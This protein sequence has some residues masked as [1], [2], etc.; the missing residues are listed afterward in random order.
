MPC[1]TR[2]EWLQGC[3]D[4]I[5]DDKQLNPANQLDTIIE[6]V[7]AQLLASDLRDS[8][9]HGSGIPA[10]IANNDTRHS[11][12]T[13]PVLVQIE[14][15]TDIGVSAYNLN[16]T[17]Q[18]RE[19]RRA[20]GARIEGEVDSDVE[21]EGP[22]PEYTRSMLR[23]EISDGATTMRAMEYRKIPELKL[24]Q[25]PLGYKACCPFFYRL[26]VFNEKRLARHKKRGSQKGYYIS[27]TRKRSS[28][29]RRRI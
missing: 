1:N 29:G 25:T 28:E 16:K 6:E 14:S 17:R 18:L 9:I 4:W 19:E 12:L 7:E 24:G 21:E 15:I 26:S 11:T 8:M 10:R 22:I 27:Y 20:A 5:I 2:Q 3:Y 13:G 23:F